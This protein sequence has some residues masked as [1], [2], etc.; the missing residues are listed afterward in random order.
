MRVAAIDIGT[1]STRL[2]VADVEAGG[3]SELF[4]HSIVTRLGDRVDVTGRLAG[5]A[6]QR[7]FDVLAGYRDEFMQAGAEIAGGVATSA[8]RDAGNGADF[9]AEIGRRL[10][11][12]IDLIGGDREAQLTFAGAGSGDAVDDQR[13]V[14]VDIGGGST[15]FIVGEAGELRFHVSTNIG[16]VRHSERFLHGDPP[17]PAELDALLDAAAAEIRERVP[18]EWRAGIKRGVAVAGTPTVLASVDLAL[19]EFD[20]WK[21]HGHAITRERCAGLLHQLAALPLAERREVTGLHPDRAPTIV[22]GAAILM[23]TLEAFELPA[24]TVSEHDILYGIALDLAA[25]G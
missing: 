8:V 24:V 23:A 13:T 19:E 22:A 4:R 15:E 5:D 18:S 7:V 6:Q 2:L 10:G 16:A 12:T 3:V 9:V 14:V 25:R 1:N 20:P 11:V 17:A 21:V